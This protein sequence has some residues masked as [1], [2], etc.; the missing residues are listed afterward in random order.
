MMFGL[1]EYPGY[2]CYD[3][4][5]PSWLPYWI[6]TPA[7][8]ICKWSPKTIAGNIWHCASGAPD[9]ANPSA[10]QQ[11]PTLSGPGIAAAGEPS[12]TPQCGRFQ[13]YNP[14]SNTCDFDPTSPTFLIIAGAIVL[15]GFV[16]MRGAK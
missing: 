12:N 8:S 2:Y 15:G 1:G 9:C 11:D 16:L 13:V 14:D 4:T 10:A 5:R 3:A 7:E 6:D